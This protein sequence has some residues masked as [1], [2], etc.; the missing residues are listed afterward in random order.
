[1]GEAAAEAAAAA[2]RAEQNTIQ[3]RLSEAARQALE[4]DVR[5]LTT[6]LEN[7]CEHLS[8]SQTRLL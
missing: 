6:E 1:M 4:L 3:L 5:A 7:I 2:T 8:P